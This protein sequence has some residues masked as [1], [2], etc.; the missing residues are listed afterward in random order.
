MKILYTII[1]VLL[2]LFV[3]TFSLANTAPVQLR[4]LDVINVS[5]PAYMLIF[6][7]FLAGVV[8]TGFMGIVERFRLN[9][10]INQLNRTIRE[11]RRELRATEPPPVLDEERKN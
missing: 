9:R 5:L 2:I 8:F 6:I 4:Y 7:C 11:L 10:T 3:I 1:V